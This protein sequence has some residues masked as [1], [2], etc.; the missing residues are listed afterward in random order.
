MMEEWSAAPPPPETPPPAGTC[1]GQTLLMPSRGRHSSPPVLLKVIFFC[2]FVFCLSLSLITSVVSIYLSMI[3][4][5]ILSTYL[6]RHLSIYDLSIYH[7]SI[8]QKKNIYHPLFCLHTFSDASIGLSIQ[9]CDAASPVS[10]VDRLTELL[11][12]SSGHKS[13]VTNGN[14]GVSGKLTLV[15]LRN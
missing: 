15:T 4:L 8:Y 6:S 10:V 11:L 7:P 2:L 13:A 3:H 14:Q 1:L 9:L 12:N 5:P